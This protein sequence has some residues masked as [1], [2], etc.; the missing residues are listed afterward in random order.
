MSSVEFA[1][2]QAFQRLEGPLGPVRADW[3]AAVV[4]SVVANANRDT[5]KHRKAYE[6]PDFIPKWD[7]NVRKPPLPPAVVQ[8]KVKAFFKGL[9]RK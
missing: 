8:D 5:R 6:P 1:E 4:A 9:P 3:R 2:W 7:A